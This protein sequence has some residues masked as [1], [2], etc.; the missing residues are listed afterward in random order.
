MSIYFGRSWSIAVK[1]GQ[2]GSSW[3]IMTRTTNFKFGKV[4]NIGSSESK[5][6]NLCQYLLLF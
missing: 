1:F 3:V 2:V 5:M 4:R 6:V